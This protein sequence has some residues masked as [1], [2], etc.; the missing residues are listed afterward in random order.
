MPVTPV[1]DPL[2]ADIRL[3]K[4]SHLLLHGYLIPFVIAYAIAAYSWLTFG[5]ES[6]GYIV[7]YCAIVL[8]LQ[9]LVVLFCFW[10]ISFRCLMLYTKVCTTVTTEC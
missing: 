6:L 10:S 5:D 8:C 2:V 4:K 1:A 9:V 3:F 7:L